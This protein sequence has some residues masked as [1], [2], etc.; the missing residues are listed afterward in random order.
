MNGNY[1]LNDEQD[2]Q[3]AVNLLKELGFAKLAL[4]C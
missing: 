1:R 4:I 2:F 3:K